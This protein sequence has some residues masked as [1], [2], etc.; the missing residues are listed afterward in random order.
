MIFRFG[1]AIVRRAG[2]LTLRVIVPA[3]V[4][5]MPYAASAD[6]EAESALSNAVRI[7][8]KL[9]DDRLVASLLARRALRPAA[10]PAEIDE[11]VAAYEDMADPDGA[12]EFLRKRL[13]IYP[14]ERHTLILLADLCVRSEHGDEG[15][16][17][18]E[19]AGTRFGLTP[20]E[21]VRLARILAKRG[22]L[23]RAQGVLKESLDRESRPS[24]QVLRDLGILSWELDD[25]ETALHAYT[26]LHDRGADS[27]DDLTRLI[28]LAE[29]AGHGHDAIAFA[30]DRY[31]RDGRPEDLL[32]LGELQQKYE[33]WSGLVLTLAGAEK[34]SAAG[35]ETYFRLE[36][37]AYTH[38]GD[39]SRAR[40]AYLAILAIDPASADAEAGLLW[41][42]IDRGD[43]ADVARFAHAFSE[44]V[45][46]SP[47]LGAPMAAARGFL[48]RPEMGDDDEEE[49][50][51]ALLDG[52]RDDEAQWRISQRLYRD[53]ES[54]RA[55]RSPVREIAYRHEPSAGASAGYV[56]LGDLEIS[57]ADVS[58]AHDAFGFRLDYAGSAS[59]LS[60]RGPDV[61]LP[62]EVIEGDLVVHA[63]RF[64]PGSLTETEIGVNMQAQRAVPR[65]YLLREDRWRG[66]AQTVV[67]AG[68]NGL[69]ANET[70]ALRVAGLR[71]RVGAS[72][73]GDLWASLYLSAEAE[74]FEDH[75]RDYSSAGTGLRQD[76]EL[77]FRILR[78]QP[79]AGIGIAVS[80][81]QRS[82]LRSLPSE[83]SVLQASIDQ[84]LP[85]SYEAVSAVVHISHGDWMDCQHR[86]HLDFPRF[87]C[88][89][90]LGVLVARK[91]YAALLSCG[92][93]IELTSATFARGG[94]LYGL[95]VA[96]VPRLAYAS[97]FLSI[98]HLF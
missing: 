77:G 61:L 85:S 82:H 10:G 12:I 36:V 88:D 93:N 21:S 97:L 96:G 40:A 2:Q 27:R 28:A 59:T 18:Y 83:L 3:V 32:G 68:V 19:E 98:N 22:K 74:A 51:L 58:V 13:Q 17:R 11:V 52:R 94:G 71:D 44:D 43:R 48:D 9:R 39:L 34:S 7:A 81:L 62:K 25:V 26:L 66:V 87:G 69:V 86:D 65:L 95:G 50:L 41:N 89:G 30:A 4:F 33:D 42:A 84:A 55:L 24:P 73:S 29:E 53:P 31:E 8:R 76:L 75:T 49:H 56:R 35:T 23:Q 16:A 1:R 70:A 57:Q 14:A 46:R 90:S 67:W 91:A 80:A 45:A 54:A 64:D 79:E 78:D 6:T 37:A 15:I 92:A 5:V 47:T 63:R 38:A 20:A 72:V 60:S